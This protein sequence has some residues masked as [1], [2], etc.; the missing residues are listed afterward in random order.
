MSERYQQNFGSC[1]LGERRLN[2]R[3]LSVGQALSENFGQALST[4]FESG[5]ALK[6]AYAFSPMPKLV[7]KSSSLPI[8]R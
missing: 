4:V 6:R 7:L 5:Q 3:A 2:R 8:V 1:E